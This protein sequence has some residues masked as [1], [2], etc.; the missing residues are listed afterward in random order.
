MNEKFKSQ[1]QSSEGGSVG[2]WG[3]FFLSM[4]GGWQM[5]MS[6]LVSYSINYGNNALILNDLDVFFSASARRIVFTG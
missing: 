4:G 5:K 3:N 2:G 6:Q 1:V